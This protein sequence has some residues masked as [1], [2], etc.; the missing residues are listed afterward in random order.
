MMNT[1]LNLG[2]NDDAV[3]I[4]AKQSGNEQFAYDSYRRFIKK[5][6]DVVMGVE[7]EEGEYDP[8]EAVLDRVKEENGYKI[9]AE[10]TAEDLKGIVEEFKAIVKA[11][12][13]K[14][15]PTNPWDQ[16]WGSVC[17]V[18][19]SWN[20]PRAILYRQKE[21]IPEEWGTAVSVQAMVYGNMGDNSGTGVCFSRD[22][23][24][25]ED[26]FNGEYLINAQGEDVVAGVRTPQEITLIGSRR[27]SERNG[28]PEEKRKAK[29]PSLEEEMPAVYNELNKI[30]QKLEDHYKDMQDM[31]FTIQDGKLWMLQT[32]N[33]KRTGA[34]MV[35][36]AVDMLA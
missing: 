22:A 11:K 8:F 28:T 21:Q 12:A 33:G 16:L 4:L 19:D 35:K 7:A 10:I 32:R 9:D 31:E 3:K 29:F 17:A 6:C 24:T 5:Y 14:E 18:F 1:V 13:G 30:Q 23:A 20:T 2:M 34:A 36:M 26:I 27:W 25:G 15:F